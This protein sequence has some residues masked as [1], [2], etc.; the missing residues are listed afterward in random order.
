[1]DCFALD[2]G[3]EANGLAVYDHGMVLR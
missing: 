3:Q 2:A 1:V